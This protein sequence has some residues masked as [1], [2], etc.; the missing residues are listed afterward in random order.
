MYRA[1]TFAHHAKHVRETHNTAES[2]DVE[3][4][5]RNYK[6]A[7]SQLR[8]AKL[9]NRLSSAQKW[10]AVYVALSRVRN[11][12]S[13]KSIGLSKK[14]RTIIEAGP[15]DELLAQ[16]EKYFGEKEGAVLKLTIDIVQIWGW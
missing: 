2:E 12:N 14:I 3:R 5:T 7:M 1:K 6:A 4:A 16:F 11:L 8:S 13:L 9:P 15:P 10:L